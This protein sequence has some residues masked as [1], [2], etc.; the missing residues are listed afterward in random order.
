LAHFE[1]G[2]DNFKREGAKN[3]NQRRGYVEDMGEKREKSPAFTPPP[4]TALF[5]HL[6]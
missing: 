4:Q 1:F 5:A 6:V 2:V 3:L